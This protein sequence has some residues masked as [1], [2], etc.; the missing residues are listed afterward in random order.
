MFFAG[1]SIAQHTYGSF[2]THDAYVNY[3]RSENKTE[4][5]AIVMVPGANLSTYLYVTTPDG[6]KGWA[7]LFADKGYDVYMVNDPR[8][9]FATGGFVEP[10]TV[11]ADGKQATP[12]SAQGWQSDIWRRW[13]FGTSQGN[14]YPNALFPTDSFN[15]FQKNY[16]YIGTSNESYSDAIQAVVETT[17]SKVWLIAHSAGASRVVTAARQKKQ[18][19]NGLILIEPAG[20]PDADD[21]PDLDGLHMFGVYGD[22]IASRNQTKRK[23]AT[24]AAAVLFQNAG[25]VADVVSLPE[26][27]LVFGNSHILMQDL[28]SEYVFNIIE[29]WL[30]QFSTKTGVI[31]G[32]FNNNISINLYPN[33][34]GNVIWIESNSMDVIEYCI[35]SMDGRLLKEATVLNQ[36][37]DLSGAP[38]GLLFIRFKHKDQVIINK[39]IKNA[40]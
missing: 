19:V 25:G 32:K 33:P 17:E 39:I 20:P 24:E 16:P 21:F 29:H 27:S 35:Y 22:Y 7:E 38:N 10:Y 6:R 37:I 1:N 14:P 26:D 11:P 12:G 28:N 9:D 3:I 18:Q 8:Y 34:T 5:A 23:L 31:E 2:Y 15:V 13:G 36:K 40:L 30:Q 4:N